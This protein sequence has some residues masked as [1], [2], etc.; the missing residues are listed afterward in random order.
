M[1]V[2]G[3]FCAVLVFGYSLIT[4]VCFGQYYSWGTEPFRV[5]WRQIKTEQ[6]QLIY[7]KG[8]DS[9]AQAIA[10]K[11]SYAQSAC[12]KSLKY[13]P[14]RISIVVHNQTNTSNGSVAWAPSQMDLY[15]ISSSNQ[16]SQE[17]F[18]DLAIH[19][20]RHVVQMNKYN[21]GKIHILSFF[22]GEQ[23][24]GLLGGIY[25]PSWLL[26]GDA[27]CTETALSNSGRGRQPDFSMG[28][29]A[30]L[31]E[32]GMYSYSKAYFG[33]Y[34]DFVPNYYVMGYY[35]LANA[36]KQYGVGLESDILDRIAY[37]PFSFRPVNNAVKDK[38][39]LSRTELYE[40]MF[41]QQANEWKLKHDREVQT[42]FDTISP[43]QSVYTNYSH[44]FQVEDSLYFVER[45]GLD[46]IEQLVKLENGNEKVVSNI[47]FK[48]SG[49]KIQSNGKTIVWEETKANIRWEMKATSHLFMYDIERNKTKKV[50][51]HRHIFAPAVSPSNERIVMFEIEKNGNYYLLFYDIP[52][53][54]FFRK[55]A[56]PNHD[57][58]QQPS[59]NENGSKIVFVGLNSQ[60]K[61][62]VEYD[63]AEDSFTELLP[64]TNDDYSTPI[65][66]HEY[67]LYVS[68]YS[69]V[70]NIYA[71]QRD[72]K[73]ISR[74]TVGNFG[75]KFPSVHDSTL[76]FS[77]YTADGF[78]LVKT[79][80]NPVAW[81]S[82]KVVKK[83]YFNLAQMLTNQEGGALDMT[84]I[85]TVPFPTKHYS[86]LL[87]GINIHSWMP[88]CLNYNGS[89][90][91]DQGFG[92]QI[93][94]QNHLGTL[95][96]SGGYKWKPLDGSQVGFGKLT[97]QGLFP[98]FEFEFD[99]GIKQYHV[100]KPD[101]TTGTITVTYD[102]EQIQGRV[103][104]P[105]NFSSKSYY[106]YVIPSVQMQHVN[107]VMNDCP[108]KY[109]NSFYEKF[110]EEIIAYTITLAN[111]RQTATQEL[112]SRFGQ[113]FFA[114]Y[115]HSL[116]KYLS[117]DYAQ[118]VY[119]PYCFASLWLYFPGIQRSH[120]LNFYV[121]AERNQ[122]ISKGKLNLNRQIQVP[123]GYTNDTIPCFEQF[124][125]LQANYALP[126]FYPDARLGD[127][128][129]IK[130]IRGNAFVDYAIAPKE[131]KEYF[132]VGAELVMDFHFLC[133]I[134][135][136]NLG[137]RYS[138]VPEKMTAYSEMI[139]SIN[140]SSL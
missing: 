122:E 134:T 5:Q 35:M 118:N 68:S 7:P 138:F 140:F 136:F 27:V 33:S 46:R 51:T 74:I 95:V 21:Q 4:S 77:N 41:E 83:D 49:D 90:V 23:A 37:R 16:D 94:S 60:G 76:V 114:G 121:G 25:S 12:I 120:N 127:F 53:K 124:Y 139:F 128:M 113:K 30:Q 101:V 15:T 88:F 22:L 61:R 130:R 100:P 84:K 79:P 133:L 92:F 24:A 34:K 99:K 44:G 11:L 17:W 65:Y 55:I 52:S 50:R 86:R 40:A 72:T 129:Y 45:K 108:T 125:S 69:G 87:H 42:T 19:E 98:V 64:Y 119:S 26:E 126:L 97:Y 28:L 56:T 32:K 62:I 116:P 8:A 38:T 135:P 96:A 31:Y 110:E 103:Y 111:L 81:H 43:K 47:G 131:E 102:I 2:F 117:R 132:S 105:L 106:R 54:K 70:D 71:L 112:H 29:R 82:L 107:L 58:V 3:K 93:N 73:Q 66:W 75:C 10:H 123:R 89:D 48:T 91:D 67:V 20:Y 13:N 39:G 36:R 9:L 6:Y 14:K 59:W 18:D 109:R 1:N 57:A 104:F 80:L 115:E 137:L 78:Q 63:V 85:D